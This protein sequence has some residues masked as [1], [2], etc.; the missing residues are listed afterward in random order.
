MVATQRELR[1]LQYNVHKSKDV[2]LADLFQKPGIAKYDILAI[3]E[4]WRNPFIDTT[5]HPLKSHFH[6]L[7]LADPMT[8]VCF[9]INKRIDPV[10]W[11]VSCLSKDAIR[12]QILNP[13]TGRT[14]TMYNVY[15]E[16]G[17]ETLEMVADSIAQ[18]ESPRNLVL[19]G[20]FNLHH[21]LWSHRQSV[22]GQDAEDLLEIIQDHQLEL[23]TA[24]GTPT[25]RWKDGETTIDLTFASEEVS[26]RLIHCKSTSAWIAIRITYQSAS[27]L[28]GH[29]RRLHPA[30]DD[31]GSKP[32]YPSCE[33]PLF[34]LVG[35]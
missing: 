10:T 35:D 12:L 29:G 20:D 31:S 23:L 26:T 2:V 21:P 17:T 8:R 5:Y 19:L 18:E 13:D 24:P 7:Y 4:P 3:Q 33:R 25:Y 1:I 27:F 6:L 30:K 34:S 32:T 28:T 22:S 9:F 15:N 14:L 11:N 16:V